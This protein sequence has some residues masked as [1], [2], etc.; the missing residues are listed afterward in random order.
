MKVSTDDV[1]SAIADYVQ[2]IVKAE[3][4]SKK[5]NITQLSPGYPFGDD[6]E[7]ETSSIVRLK[8]T[9]DE[10]PSSDLDHKKEHVKV[11]L[12]ALI[13]GKL[14]EKINALVSELK[15]AQRDEGYHPL[16]D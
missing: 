7:V 5:T 2:A 11:L 8:V 10:S 3:S 6:D 4:S 1:L 9:F 16:Y 12:D 15:K 14:Q 13:D